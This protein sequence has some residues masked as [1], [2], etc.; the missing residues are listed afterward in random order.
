MQAGRRTE[1]MGQ[2][3]GDVDQDGRSVTA[4]TSNLLHK[5]S[6]GG[7]LVNGKASGRN[8]V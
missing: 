6:N 5:H 8:L 7:V 4:D 2:P 1:D 3:N